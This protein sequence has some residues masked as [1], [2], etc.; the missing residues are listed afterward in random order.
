MLPKAFDKSI[1]IIATVSLLSGFVQNV[2][3]GRK[4][5]YG[6]VVLFTGFIIF[7]NKVVTCP[8]F[9]REG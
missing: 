6:F 1:E 5:S 9:Q 2:I 7:L 4:N 8:I 3:E